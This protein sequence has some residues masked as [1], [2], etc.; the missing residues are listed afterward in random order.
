MKSKHVP[1]LVVSDSSICITLK[2]INVSFHHQSLMFFNHLPKP[3]RFSPSSQFLT[4]QFKPHPAFDSGLSCFTRA[5]VCLVQNSNYRASLTRVT[6]ITEEIRLSDAPQ[7]SGLPYRPF[8]RTY[9]WPQSPGSSNATQLQHKHTWTRSYTHTHTDCESTAPTS[10][11]LSICPPIS[12]E[13]Y[14]HICS[15]FVDALIPLKDY[16]PEAFVFACHM[17]CH[18]REI[19]HINPHRCVN[20]LKITACNFLRH[21]VWTEPDMHTCVLMF[22]A[23]LLAE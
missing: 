20:R 9:C 23:S 11:S 22:L 12:N 10:H 3:R 2:K 21:L 18:W 15:S 6:G 13:K 5:E 14:L 19:T 17:T 16:Q 4:D 1:A 7:S 8:S